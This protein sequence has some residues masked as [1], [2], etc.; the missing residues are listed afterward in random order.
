MVPAIFLEDR[1]RHWRGAPS[2]LS[3][4]LKLALV[5]ETIQPGLSV[6]YVAH[7]HGLGYLRACCFA[8]GD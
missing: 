1:S 4:E 8:K 6:S 5:A 7:R 3:T 2:T